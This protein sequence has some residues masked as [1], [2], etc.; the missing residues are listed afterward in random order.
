MNKYKNVT[1][2]LKAFDFK[3]H[4]FLTIYLSFFLITLLISYILRLNNMEYY[5]SYNVNQSYQDKNGLA[6]NFTYIMNFI[7]IFSIGSS[8]YKYFFK[9]YI[10]TG[11][12]NNY[13]RFDIFIA[14]YIKKILICLILVIIFGI[15]IMFGSKTNFN[16]SFEFNY[17]QFIFWIVVTN[18]FELF[19]LI[20][21]KIQ[22]SK[23]T[24]Y[25]LISILTLILLIIITKLFTSL[26]WF[27]SFLKNILNVLNLI[28]NLQYLNV[29][30]TQN[31]F[32][33]YIIILN[34]L[35]ISSFLVYKLMLKVNLKSI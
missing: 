16:V 14:I 33:I 28:Y 8:V 35:I 29:T 34:V 19:I 5:S 18:I 7:I 9:R 15:K 10:L 4:I 32:I 6:L 23:K 2:L 12:L 30:N 3:I 21:K 17:V 13:S 27:D 20:I 26:N 24:I 22:N 11:I 1:K 31:I 25:T